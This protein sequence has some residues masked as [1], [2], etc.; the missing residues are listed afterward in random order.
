MLLVENTKMNIWELLV[1]LNFQSSSKKNLHYWEMGEL[2]SQ[3]IKLYKKLK[4]LRNHGL[5]SRRVHN[6]GTN[7]RLDN[8]QA[9]FGN[10]MI[11]KISKW[12][13]KFFN[14]ANYYSKNLKHLS[15]YDI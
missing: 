12:N 7:S 4:L 10:I 9:S 2:L 6:L 11:S 5:R 14:I 3:K 8:M 15:R 1:I 13:K